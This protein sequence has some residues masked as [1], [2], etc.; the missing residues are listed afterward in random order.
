MH[1]RYGFVHVELDDA[2]L[3]N[4]WDVPAIMGGLY[5]ILVT[6]TMLMSLSYEYGEVLRY[7]RV[8]SPRSRV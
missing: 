6:D 3:W 8:H 7:H 4:Y 1:K 5:A 2:M